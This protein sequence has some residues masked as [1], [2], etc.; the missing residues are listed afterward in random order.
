MHTFER[1]HREARA[2]LH[3]CV[4][5][6][7]CVGAGVERRSRRMGDGGEQRGHVPDVELVAR[8]ARRE[9]LAVYT[10]RQRI[11]PL[12]RRAQ[13]QQRLRLCA[14]LVACTP[15]ALQLLIGVIIS[16]THLLCHSFIHSS[17]RVE[18]E[19]EEYEYKHVQYNH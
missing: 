18:D 19:M 5:I 10:P 14:L 15:A 1:V 4:R 7:V 6:C 8:A 13:R 11:Q 16:P 2:L 3:V 12:I 9:Q 17:L